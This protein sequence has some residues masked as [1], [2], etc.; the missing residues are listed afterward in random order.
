MGHAP[1]PLLLT[2]LLMYKD[3]VPRR[4]RFY[5][6][7]LFALFYQLSGGI[8]LAAMSQM[9]GETGFLRED[10][11]MA[12]YCSLIGLN[13]I[14]PV[15]FRWKFYCFTRQMFFISAVGALLCS[16]AAMHA[17]Q[18]WILWL[19]CLLAGYFKMMGMFSCMSN[20][21][22]NVTPTRNYGV[23]FPVVYI[24]VCG[25]M[26]LSGIITAY[27]CYAYNWRMVYLIIVAFMLI[28]DAVV[29]FMMKPDHRSAPFIPLKGIDWTG[30]LLWVLS[31]C[32]AAWIFTFGEHYDWWNST[33]IWTATWLFILV[34]AATLIESHFKKEPFIDLKAFGYSTTWTLM[35]L[36]FGMAVLQTSTH[37]LQPVF[38]NLAGYDYFSSIRFN[39]AELAGVVMGAIGAYFMLVRW[40][41]GMKKFFFCC[42]L[43]VCIY[44][45]SMYF[46]IDPSTEDYMFYIP[47]FF[48]GMGEVMMETGVTFLIAHSIP[49][50]HFFM[51]IAIVGF[52]RCGVGTAAAGGM[53]ERFFSWAMAKNT[54]LTSALPVGMDMAGNAGMAAYMAQQNLMISIKECLGYLA[55]FG[56]LM[57]VFIL[58][59][60][61]ASTFSRF[62]P[63]LVSV[64][65]WMRNPR[66]PDPTMGTVA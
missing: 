48:F 17:P 16:I 32:I 51:N 7:M 34:F 54:M 41:W 63:R 29:Y 10:F 47:L 5:L 25:A 9:V 56:I 40:K 37:V 50:P 43:F 21:Q 39:W 6:I 13:M 28:I 45:F 11:T 59:S 14:F 24:L 3:W 57:M 18:P 65:R 60:N 20:I 46:L 8:Y 58:L 23:F 31:C 26:Q 22:L 53:V 49:F 38:T 64:A 1:Q 4:L 19:I 36:L 15:L 2:R 12:C 52:V 42:F 62:V 27:V 30:H 44:I 35:F 66:A 33:E 55:L 61:F